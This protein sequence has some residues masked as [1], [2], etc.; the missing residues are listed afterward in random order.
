[1]TD[2]IEDHDFGFTMVSEE[3][4]IY[5]SQTYKDKMLK[6]HKMITPLLKNLL[7]DPDKDVIH[8]PGREKKIKDFIKKIDEIVKE[9]K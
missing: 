9:D 3:D 1:M 6:L 8:W 5:N 4:M 2:E 7:K